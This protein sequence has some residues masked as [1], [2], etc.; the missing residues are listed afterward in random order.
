MNREKKGKEN[1]TVGFQDK[2]RNGR[3][4]ERMNFVKKNVDQFYF[5]YES[6]TTLKQNEVTLKL[7]AH[8]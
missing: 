3:N 2:T 8:V 7:E 1:I 6:K 5:F 4:Q